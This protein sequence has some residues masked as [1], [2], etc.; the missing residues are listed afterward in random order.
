MVIE[1]DELLSR[2]PREAIDALRSR[3]EVSNGQLR[4]GKQVL[5]AFAP[6]VDD[7]DHHP[8]PPGL[9]MDHVRF[10][11]VAAGEQ[12]F[13]RDL[14]GFDPRRTDVL[15]AYY[16]SSVRM[17]DLL[18]VAQVGTEA[19]VSYVIKVATEMAWQRLVTVHPELAREFPLEMLRS[20]GRVR[21]RTSEWSTGPDNLANLARARTMR[22]PWAHDREEPF[23]DP[24][25]SACG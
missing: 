1:T 22:L 18:D 20:T 6:F 14:D 25:P 11:A 21:G 12:I 2:D 24:N 7:P 23:Q 5:E 8:L 13:D 19:A 10:F 16:P 9:T 4:R 17:R 3:V 15:L